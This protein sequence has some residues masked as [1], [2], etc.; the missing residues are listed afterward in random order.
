MQNV[1]ENGVTIDIPV[2]F[3]EN[4][5][6]VLRVKDIASGTVSNNVT[7]TVQNR[8]KYEKYFRRSLILM[9]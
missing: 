9:T 7:V 3:V 2:T 1:S 6:V 8:G 4:G 5:E